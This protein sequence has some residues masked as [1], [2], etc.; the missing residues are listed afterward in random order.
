MSR[1]DEIRARPEAAT[2]GN[3]DYKKL[4][5]IHQNYPETWAWMQSKAKWERVCLSTV[6]HNY[7]EHINAL[8]ALEHE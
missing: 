3:I 4:S 5:L 7:S 1:L 8:M 6:L 2:P